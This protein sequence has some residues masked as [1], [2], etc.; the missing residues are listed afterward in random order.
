[1]TRRHREGNMRGGMF[2]REELDAMLA[3]PGCAGVRIYFARKEDGKD[4]VVM[5]GVDADGRDMT[6][7]VLME[8]IIPCPP[9]CGD[10]SA[11]NS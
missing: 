2:F 7:G 8:E 10:G 11:L 6:S 4:T 5:T 3:Q 9:F 1:M